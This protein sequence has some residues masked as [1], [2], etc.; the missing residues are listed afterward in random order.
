MWWGHCAVDAAGAALAAADAAKAAKAPRTRREPVPDELYV[1]GL[2]PETAADDVREAFAL[3]GPVDVRVEG[4]GAAVVRLAPGSD[5]AAVVAATDRRTA[6]L[7]VTV[8]VVQS[9]RVVALGG[10]MDEA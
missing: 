3:H 8:N 1:T 6:V 4:A 7:G 9:Q 10:P 5:V 2:R